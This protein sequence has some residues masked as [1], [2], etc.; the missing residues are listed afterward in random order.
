MAGELVPL[1]MLPR[2]TTYAGK[3]DANQYFTTIGMDVTAYQGA[4]I[5]IWRGGLIGT[6]GDPL[7]FFDESTDQ[8]SWTACTGSSSGGETIVVNTEE[9]VT[10]TFKKRWFRVRV[11]LANADNILTCWAVGFLEER[12]S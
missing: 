11:Q 8:V 3:V 5:N 10:L 1:V 9:Q 7:F 6:A 12:E 2:Y 4:I